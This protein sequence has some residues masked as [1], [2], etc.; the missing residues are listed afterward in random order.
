NAENIWAMNLYDPDG[1]RTEIQDLRK[2]PNLRIAVVGLVHGHVAGFFNRYHNRFDSHIV[3]IAEPDAQLR[4]GY[5]ARYHLDQ[6]LFFAR[7]EEMLDQTKPQAVVVFTNTYDH[8]RVVEACA[9][10]G[11]HV[12][13]EKPLAVSL[14]H[15]HAMERAAAKGHI[16]VLVNYETTWYASNQAAWSLVHEKKALG[17][18]RKMVA[19]DGHRGPKEI[20]VQP[21]FLS[22]LTDPALGGAGALFDFGCYGADLMTWLMDGQRPVSVTAVTQ[23]I[24]PQIYPKT[25]DEATIVVTY[26]RA[27]GIIQASW[28]WPFDRKDLEVYGQ[29]GYVKTVRLEQVQQRLPG[30]EEEQITVPPLKP[31][32]DDPISYLTA[33]V[34]GEIQP[35]GLSALPVNV[36]SMEILDAARRSAA[37]GQT[38]RLSASH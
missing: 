20:G 21:E 37:T 28:N 34:R 30:K 26:P 18:I 7:L 1:T 31:R 16:Q 2:V 17:E 35:E 13:M 5:A 8:L 22:W 14:E 24:K 27:Q 3:G 33:V 32:Y 9:A 23:Q 10:R 6:S 11:I 19:H 15:A 36:I 12:M 4:A 25:D 38:I 29:N